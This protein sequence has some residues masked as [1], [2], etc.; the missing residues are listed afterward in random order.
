M[1]LTSVF[2]FLRD[3]LW[4]GPAMSYYINV[5]LFAFGAELKE[6]FLSV[7][8]YVGV[9]DSSHKYTDCLMLIALNNQTVIKK[10]KALNCDVSEI[11]GFHECHNTRWLIKNLHPSQHNVRKWSLVCTQSIEKQQFKKCQQQH[12]CF[13]NDTVKVPHTFVFIDGH[14]VNIIPLLL[15]HV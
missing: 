9:P 12:L 13:H 2:V 1:S 6:M 4:V 10:K 14:G 11:N 7:V 5:Q 8:T 3:G 15:R